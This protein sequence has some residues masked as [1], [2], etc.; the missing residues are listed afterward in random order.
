MLSNAWEVHDFAPNDMD[1]SVVDNKDVDLGVH[2]LQSAPPD[3]LIKLMHLHEP[4]VVHALRHQYYDKSAGRDICNRI[5][6]KTGPIL[7]VVNPFCKDR[8]GRLYGDCAVKMY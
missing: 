8:T 1:N 3:S 2:G 5:Y 4:S 7:L 6:T